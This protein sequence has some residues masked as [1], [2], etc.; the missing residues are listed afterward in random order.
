MAIPRKSRKT[1]SQGREDDVM[2][3]PPSD[4]LQKKCFQTRH[5]R[6]LMQ[7]LMKYWEIGL[8]QP[9]VSAMMYSSIS[10]YSPDDNIV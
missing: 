3:D 8:N 5:K 1:M 10:F 6:D 7:N 2:K 9:V 4:L